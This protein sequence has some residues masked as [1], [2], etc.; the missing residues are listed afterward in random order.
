MLPK[1]AV[2]FSEPDLKLKAEKLSQ[3]LH[4]P[5]TI[6]SDTHYDYVLLVTPTHLGLN[7]I[8]D[9]YRLFYIDFLSGKLA[10]R[11]EHV[12]L[13]TESLARALGL[14]HSNQPKI[15]DATAGFARDSFILASLGFEITLLERSPIV[16]KLVKDGI[17]RALD[18]PYVGPIVNRL[19]LIQTDAINWLQE[20]T[21]PPELIYLDPM[22]PERKNSAKVK[23]EMQLLQ[24]LL[25]EEDDAETLLKQALACATRRVVVKR[26]RLAK[27][28]LESPSFSIKGSSC[29]FD[30]YLIQGKNGNTNPVA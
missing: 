21:E 22:F 24:N 2:S 16:Y 3:E 15:I 25:G 29:R 12:S 30:V 14:T 8:N 1:I 18:N 13:R 20:I 28:L 26:P 9:K 10:Y 5:L 7:K 19:H 11:R 23:K 17:E 4:L 27:S 6:P